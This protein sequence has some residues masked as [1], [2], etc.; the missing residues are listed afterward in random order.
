MSA[1]PTILDLFCG[2]GG[3]A[4]GYFQAGFNPVGVDKFRQ[5]RY[6]FAHYVED[7]FEFLERYGK[8]YDAIHASP[9]CQFYSRAA[10][11]K[12]GHDDF[13]WEV[14]AYL[15]QTGKPYVIENVEDAKSYLNNPF[16]LCGT[17]FGLNVIR[18]R[19]FETNWALTQPLPE[20]NHVKPVVRMGRRPTELEYHSVVGHFIGAQEAREAMGIDWM[21]RNELAQA[22]PPAYT[23]WIGRQLIT[24]L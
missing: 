12:G 23:E 10:V 13:I 5:K 22:I 14:R 3:C 8:H 15:V 21:T 18:H 16:C 1:K 19:L 4:M 7:A 20:C 9:P 2:A 17:M 6:P 24:M 11:N